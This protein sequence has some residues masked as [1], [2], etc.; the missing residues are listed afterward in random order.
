MFIGFTRVIVGFIL[1][2]DVISSTPL[3]KV[4]QIIQLVNNIPKH[5]WKAGINFHP[6]LLTNVSHLMGVLPLNKLSEKDILLTYDVSID[7]ESLP[8][9]YD[10][11]QTWSECKSVVSIRDQSN[12][13]SC[14]ALSTASAFS[15]R[16]CI[17]SNMNVNKVLSGEYIN[18]CCNGKCGDG[19]NG[20]HPE[21]AWKYIKKNG[22]C[23]G[24]EYGSN[25]G[26]Q[27]YSIVPCPRNANSCSKENEDTPQCYKDQCT[28]NNYETPL[29]SDLYY[30]YKVYSVKPKPE[31]IMS[32]IFKNGPVVAAMKVYE[33]FVCYK[34]GIYQYTTGG[35]K[36]DHAVK[37]MGW[38]Q[39]DGID[40]WLCANTWGDSWGMGGMFKIRRGRNECGIEN[41]IT[42]GLPKV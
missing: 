12:C 38:G 4:N 34:G 26:C 3:F 31:I 30:A 37:I 15:D 5:T 14:W 42:G 9:S 11:T 22:L 25:E 20:G 36:G 8:E 28:N 41:R 39:D 1:Y 10:V 40:Y 33:D 23:T 7:L 32:E 18:S 35:L 13:G 27:P 29:V 2:F 21:K 16:L 17:T 19:C 6:S 24:G